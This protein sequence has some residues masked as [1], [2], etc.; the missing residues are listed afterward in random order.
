M[1]LIL[2]VSIKRRIYVSVLFFE[3]SNNLYCMNCNY[4][5]YLVGYLLLLRVG[6]Q[7]KCRFTRSQNKEK[8]YKHILPYLNLTLD[9]WLDRER[10]IYVLRVPLTLNTDRGL[11]W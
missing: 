4:E 1:H 6:C 2:V 10:V 7:Y 5:I 3:M 9:R 11:L 8:S